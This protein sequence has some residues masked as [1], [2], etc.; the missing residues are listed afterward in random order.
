LRLGIVFRNDALGIGTRTS[1]NALVFNGKA[2][3]DPANLGTNVEISPYDPTQPNQTAIV[4]DYV[5][6]APDIIVLAGTAEAVTKVMSPLEAAWKGGADAGAST[7]PYYVLIDSVKVPELIAAVTGNDDLRRRVR[8]T[9]VT[10]AATSAP[11]LNAFKV[12]YLLQYPTGSATTSGM[13]PS[14]DATYAIAYAI[15]ATSGQPVTGR[16][17]AQGLRKLAG[18]TTTIDIENTQILAAFQALVQGQQIKAIGT[19]GPLAWD[20][21]GAVVGGTIEMWCIGATAAIPAFGSSG[22]VYDIASGQAHG[23]YAQCGP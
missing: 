15:A 22:L 10:P 9:G 12:D 5:N 11:V 8:G 14:Y 18:G 4:D 20:K 1:L 23:A 13:G 2:L 3:A 7:R 17:I 6:F 19:Y 16:T 21:N